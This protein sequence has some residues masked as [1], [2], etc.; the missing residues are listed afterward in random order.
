M[1]KIG[2]LWFEQPSYNQDQIEEVLV[3][4]LVQNNI[5]LGDLAYILLNVLCEVLKD[6][7]KKL[8]ETTPI[9]EDNV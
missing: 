7:L 4:H 6:H 2:D 5:A 8:L 1:K 3:G 9:A